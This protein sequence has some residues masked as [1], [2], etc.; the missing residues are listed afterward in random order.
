MKL[1]RTGWNNVIIFA[2][3]GFILMI[4][5]TNNKIFNEQDAGASNQEVSLLADGDIILT[6]MVN[7]GFSIERAGT[8]WTMQP[9]YKLNAQQAEQMMRAWHQVSGVSIEAVDLTAHANVSP[10]MVSY[11]TATGQGIKMLSLYPLNDMLV[12]HNHQKN[13]YIALPLPLFQQ[14]VPSAILAN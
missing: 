8:G 14:L 9:E 1:S 7:Q 12:V 4:N 10:I 13:A 5:V 2:V 11:M 3:M 6:M